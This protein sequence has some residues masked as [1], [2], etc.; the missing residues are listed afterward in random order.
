[1]ST[2][3]GRPY[4]WGNMYFYN[5]CSAEILNFY[6]PFGIWLPRHSSE[7]AK[8]GKLVDK[9]AEDVVGRIKYLIENGK[10][11]TTIVYIGGHVMLYIGNYPN[12]NSDLHEQMAMTYQNIWGLKPADGSYR[13]II[14]MSVLLPIL[15]F[16]SED[17]DI[18]SLA[19][20]KLFQIIYLDG[21]KDAEK[22]KEDL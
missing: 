12:K 20:R 10:K 17:L 2:L 22:S 19:S 5:D 7:Q 15:A 8:I 14:G 1:M 9:S 3:L 13:S 18:S 21:D 16:Y 6:T 11:F 4:G